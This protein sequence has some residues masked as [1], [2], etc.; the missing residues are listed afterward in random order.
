MIVK[1]VRE[2]GYVGEGKDPHLTLGN[3][4]IVFRISYHITRG[5]HFSLPCDSEDDPIIL[6]ASF[7]EIVDKNVPESF[8]F[9]FYEGGHACLQP[10]EFSG[11]FWDLYHDGD[12]EAEKTFANVVKRLK[13]FYGW[14]VE[15]EDYLL[16]YAERL[17]ANR[18]LFEVKQLIDSL[19][20]QNWNYQDLSDVMAD[21]IAKIKP[22]ENP[23][24]S[25]VLDVWAVIFNQSL[26]T[27]NES[28]S[29]PHQQLVGD[30]LKRTK[31]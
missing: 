18:F 9:E 20:I 6:E 19:K 2:R 30:I 21:L 12:E 26:D 16:P 28:I 7:F 8:I 4:Y 14:P 3:E 15:K 13:L 24:H 11:D 23:L 22:E 1:Y 29:A 31:S 10:K 27:P 25:R 17:S 5:F